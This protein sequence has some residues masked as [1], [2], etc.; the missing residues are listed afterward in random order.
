MADWNEA[1]Q[2]VLD[3]LDEKQN[4]LVSAA[5]GS[6]KTAVLVERII[7]TVLQ[8]KAGIDEILVVTFTNAAAAQMK[9]KIIAALERTISESGNPALEK[10]L[11]LAENADIMTIDSFCGK[12]VRDNF[13]LADIDPSYDIYDSEEI[14]LLQEDILDEVLDGYYRDNAVMKKLAGFL[15]SKNKDDS[16]IKKF[17]L[18]ISRVADSFAVPEKWIRDA[19]EGDDP[20][21][22]KDYHES[23]KALAQ[24][25]LEYLINCRDFMYENGYVDLDDKKKKAMDS[26]LEMYD[27]DISLMMGIIGSESLAD[28]KLRLSGGWKSFQKKK[29]EP[30]FDDE[31]LEDFKGK[32]EKI[33]KAFDLKDIY[34]E[35]QIHHE[36]QVSRDYIDVLLD[37]T[38]SFRERLMQEKKKQK[39]YEFSDIS[40]AAY[41]VLSDVETGEETAVAK[42][43]AEVYKYIY[44]DEYQDSND[45]QENILN[46]VAR[47]NDLG[48]T[49]NVFMV[50][51]VKQSIYGFRLA[52]PELFNEKA[53]RYAE[54]DGGRLIHLNMNYRSRADI[55]AAAN[56]VFESV[57]TKAFGGIEYDENVKLNTP[58]KDVYDDNFPEADDESR[59]GGIPEVILINTDHDDN[60]DD[61]DL[62][63]EEDYS[64]DE[65]ETIEI[66]RRIKLLVEGDPGNGIEP[67][68][69]RNE[70][71]RKD[72]PKSERNQPY[73]PV[74]YGDIVIL[75]R[76]TKGSSF[77]LGIFEQMEIPVSLEDRNGYFDAIEIVTVLS[78]LRVI[79]NIQQDIPYASLL[80]SPMAG[81]SEAELAIIVSLS[82]DRFMSL[83]DKCR[84]FMEGYID[85]EDASLKD[86]ARKL[87]K[88]NDL[89]EKWSGLRPYVDIATLVDTIV[90]DTDYDAYVAAMPDGERR[91]A[92]LKILGVRARKFEA[93]KTS[94][95]MDFLRYID[96][97]RIHDID[98][99]EARAPHD[100][101][102]EVRIM[103]IHKSKGLEFPVVFVMSLGRGFIMKDL[104]ENVIADGNYHVAMNQFS[105]VKDKIKVK[106]KSIKKEIIKTLKQQSLKAE[107][108]RLLYVAMT[109]AKEKLILSGCYSKA[110]PVIPALSDNLLDFVRY[111]V[112]KHDPSDK[113]LVV[114]KLSKDLIIADFT[115][116]FVKKNFDYTED[117]TKLLSKIDDEKEKNKEKYEAFGTDESLYG[118]EYP[119]MDAANTRAKKSVS[120][121]KHEA[122]EDSPTIEIPEEVLEPEYPE[123]VA[124]EESAES[125][126]D[127]AVEKAAEMEAMRA[128]AATRGTIIHALF[129]KLDYGR[130]ASKET[131]KAEFDRV[132]AGSHFEE[133]E[134]VLVDTSML[135]RFYSED[136]DSLFVRMKRAYLAGKLYREQQFIAGLNLDEL[137][138]PEDYTV[139]QGIID[140]FFYEGDDEHIILVDYKTDNVKTGDELIGRYAAQMYL[141]ATT[142]EK[143][144]GH[145]VVDVILYSTRFGE[146]HYTDWRKKNF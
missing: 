89:I 129:E 86:I 127:A 26:I 111:A 93:V 6:G 117:I 12:V 43:L 145:R 80:T 79:D 108:S 105:L 136:E 90:S 131:L 75:K 20:A 66:G 4:I 5:A 18:A 28:L 112:E 2:E 130:V 19:R 121:I 77:M 118:F 125:P 51:D 128:R 37:I 99:G 81:I 22:I 74:R 65:A 41:R 73:R 21:W 107:E 11:A 114:E 109:R 142:L 31:L 76:A 119:F 25:S 16:S 57:M 10:Q 116:A 98:F 133:E 124:L 34:D 62:V 69:I 78:A 64:N 59:V 60:D 50:G 35:D 17:I 8:G 95:L 46:C 83:A 45:L 58:P 3:S 67:L 39:K 101:G 82:V 27:E 9:E 100:V 91:I 140:A 137:K 106:D 32:R 146:V 71:Y 102:N 61:P 56:F 122:M 44:I 24:D 104:S 144:T 1:Q 113:R 92:N 29:L 70:E 141:Y 132:L 126:D 143:L 42:R 48:N 47:K 85:S 49:K 138:S 53:G 134:K 30:Y 123:K 52:R 115:K 72:R 120:E 97:C 40:H 68:L 84:L 14:S 36:L 94:G 103:S 87:K 23:L 38:L 88:I 135:I 33:K 110:T 139:I 7:R 55:L 15:M 96:K 63:V 13:S 54:D